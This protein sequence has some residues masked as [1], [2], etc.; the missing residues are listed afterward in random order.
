MAFLFSLSLS[1]C[2][3]SVSLSS[4]LHL[5]APSLPMC[6]PLPLCVSQS[7][8][9]FMHVSISVSVSV[10]LPLS[11]FVLAFLCLYIFMSD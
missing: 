5:S 7:V 9:I 4:S 6:V 3:R 10:S 11:V 2:Y 1:V 8:C